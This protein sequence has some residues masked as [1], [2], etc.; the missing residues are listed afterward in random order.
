MVRGMSGSGYRRFTAL[1]LAAALAVCA[2]CSSLV[3]DRTSQTSGT[4][5]SKGTN[6]NIIWYEVPMA[7][8]DIARDNAAD[9]R[10]TNVKVTETIVY[11]YFG[12]WLDWIYQFL[13]LRFAVIKGTW[14]FTGDEVAD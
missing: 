9:S 11:P 4:F 1:T 13:G 10:L 14:G 5:V 8:I 7:A 3:V 12:R 6:L 2:S